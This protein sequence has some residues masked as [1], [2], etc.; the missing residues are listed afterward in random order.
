MA[1]SGDELKGLVVESLEHLGVLSSI[2]V[3][4]LPA[5]KLLFSRQHWHLL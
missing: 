2:K 1:D 5:V 3:R 4:I